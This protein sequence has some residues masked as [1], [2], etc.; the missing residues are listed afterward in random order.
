MTPERYQKIC[1]LYHRALELTPDERGDFLKVTCS[2]DAEL[3]QEVESMLRAHECAGTYFAAP[4]ME[5]AVGLLAGRTPPSL[6]GQTFH[7]YQVLSLLGVGGMGEVY[8]AEDTRLGRKVAIK[9]LP[10]EF[11]Q[12]AERVRRFEQEARAASALNHPNIITIHE[13]GQVD[14]THYIITEFVEGQTLREQ[15]SHT[16][17]GI[18]TALEVAAQVASAL[19]AAHS[20]G[21][22]HRDIKPDNVMVRPDGLIKVLD[23]G[24]AKLGELHL[25]GHP[26]KSDGGPHKKTPIKTAAGIIMGTVT[27]M[28]PEQ[29][30]GQNVDARSDIFSLG[31]VL[32]EMI[33]GEP[34]FGGETAADVIISIVQQEPAPL[35]SDVPETPPE[36]EQIVS[37]ALGKEREDRYQTATELLTDLKGLQQRLQLETVS[38]KVREKPVSGRGYR[39][40]PVSRRV[41]PWALAAGMVVLL[42]I[43]WQWLKRQTAGTALRPEANVIAVLPFKNLSAEKESEYFADGLT[44][45]IIRSLS[46]IEGLEVRSR[47]SSF[48]F[49]DKPRNIHDVGE[50]MK[51]NWVLEGSV[52]RSG[53]NLRI[54]AQLIRVADDT[55]LWTG[56]FDRELRDVFTIQDE[57]SNGIVNQLRL[58]L[59]R[60]RRR[61]ETSVEAYDLYLRAGGQSSVPGPELA[62]KIGILEQ[63]IAKDP[64]FAPAWAGLASAYA[65][66]SIAFPFDNAADA[67]ARLRTAAE[68]AFQLDPLLPEAHAAIGMMH[69]RES[70]W[71]QAENSFRQAI[72]LD[73]NR[74]ETYKDYS[75]WVLMALGRVDDALEQLRNATKTD[76][77]SQDVKITLATA[78]FSGGR[79]EEVGTYLQQ[80]PDDHNLK[81]MY[82]ARLQLTQGN[83]ERAIEIL[84]NDPTRSRNPQV[85]GLL[86]YVYARSGRREE[87]EKMAAASQQANEQA[88]IFAGLGDKDRTLEALD[89]MGSRGPQ[90]VGL[91]LTFPEFK[92]LEGDPRLIALRK[93]V[94]LPH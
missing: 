22:V 42:L 31:V 29:A 70:R 2:S 54:I 75:F 91:S 6:V 60:G 81:A 59:G 45:E 55:P 39:S 4:A 51:A 77:L 53:G 57:I 38:G 8:L 3:G 84:E 44:D 94:G 20:A 30:R 85:R 34:P 7:H 79:Y 19:A 17:T 71:V 23:F 5:V 50:Q 35:V 76:P 47:T 56:R 64:S 61:Y 83:I 52:L 67:V 48:T 16:R 66:Q 72:K 87:A 90:R 82:L 69:A 63:V 37:K 9:L 58:N 14:S 27:Y 33:S 80:L 12:D 93:K 21:I 11:T 1:E 26:S 25:A 28:S 68:K 89:R 49:K 36:L 92:F 32:Y 46:I 86:G 10:A 40:S 15:M 78:L 88:L 74:S 18:S 13:V 62:K 73:P 43:G 41:W 24:L 65:G